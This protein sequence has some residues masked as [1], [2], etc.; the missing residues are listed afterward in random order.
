M[1][2]M[3]VMMV[4]G[5]LF[6]GISLAK[7]SVSLDEVFGFVGANAP[8]GADG[9]S[10]GNATTATPGFSSDNPAIL[11]TYWV[12]GNTYN[13]SAFGGYIPLQNGPKIVTHS[14]AVTV[15][16]PVGTGQIYF[17]DSFSAKSPIPLGIDARIDRVQKLNFMY[18]VEVSRS[19]LFKDDSLNI[20]VSVTPPIGSTALSFFMDD[21]L[22]SKAVSTEYAFGGGLLYRPTKKI[23]IGAS[24]QEG[25]T[26]TIETNA[27][28][29][30]TTKK[31]S[32]SRLTKFGVGVQAMEKLLLTVEYQHINLGTTARN[33]VAAG[34]ELCV[35]P[36]V[37]LYGGHNGN[38][39][40]GGLGIY[41]NKNV[42]INVGYMQ[43]V[44]SSTKQPLEGAVNDSRDSLGSSP[45]IAAQINLA[46]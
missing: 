31:R 18:G 26:S 46:F 45:T 5:L 13:M 11:P 32:T 16:F 39:F 10:I 44:S 33:Q 3:V 28:T 17:T 1:K 9:A 14:E 29:E 23:S 19:F 30:T 15:K 27:L 38:G 43:N 8:R 22:M 20:G 25:H 40:T 24:Y 6:S 4:V 34:A 35:D 7:E 42:S 12:N 36:T 2:K 37:C 21:V 41:P